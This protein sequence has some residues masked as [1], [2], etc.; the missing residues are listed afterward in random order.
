MSDLVIVAVTL[1]FAL[2]SWGLIAIVEHLSG[3]AK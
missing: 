2:M 1:G 3:G